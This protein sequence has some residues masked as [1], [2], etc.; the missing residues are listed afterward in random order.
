MIELNFEFFWLE[1]LSGVYTKKK[2]QNKNLMGLLVRG[3]GCVYM[4]MYIYIKKK[5]Y[6]YTYFIPNYAK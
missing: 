6:V 3:F 5:P 2:K 1:I 4:Y